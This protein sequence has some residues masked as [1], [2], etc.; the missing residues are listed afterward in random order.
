MGKTATSPKPQAL[1]GDDFWPLVVEFTLS[2][3]AWWVGICAEFELTPMQGHALRMLE[4]GSPVAMSALASTLSCDA[5]NVTV[6]VDRLEA[7]GLIARQG[8]EHD[9][10]IKMLAVTEAGRALRERL[11]ARLMEPPASVSALSPEVRRRLAAV[12][13]AIVDE[14]IAAGLAREAIR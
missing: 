10:R 11:Q 7:R 5:S 4:P 3:K 1:T 6:L 12:L 14:R 13:R 8:A 2:Q 9:R